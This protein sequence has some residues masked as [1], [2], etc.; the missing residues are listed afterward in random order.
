MSA[1]WSQL[2]VHLNAKRRLD[3]SSH[4]WRTK[5]ARIQLQT[6][7]DETTGRILSP[8]LETRHSHGRKSLKFATFSFSSWLFFIWLKCTDAKDEI[9]MSTSWS[10]QLVYLSAETKLEYWSHQMNRNSTSDYFSHLESG[11]GRILSHNLETRYSQGSK[12]LKFATFKY[13]LVKMH[14]QTWSLWKRLFAIVPHKSPPSP[15]ERTGQMEVEYH[16]QTTKH[17]ESPSLSLSPAYIRCAGCP[18]AILTPGTLNSLCPATWLA[19]P[20]DQT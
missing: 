6:V 17:C 13:S 20:W 11:K 3:S 9:L 14:R 1:R 7:F 12:S 4:L 2:L 19:V 5:W 18:G 15:S 16:W 8:N 10:Q